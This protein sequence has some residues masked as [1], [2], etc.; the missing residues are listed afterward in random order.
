MT[1]LKIIR[2]TVSEKEVSVLLVTA[3]IAASGVLVV[4]A[5]TWFCN[6]LS[7][8]KVYD[9]LCAA[10]P[11]METVEIIGLYYLVIYIRRGVQKIRGGK[12]K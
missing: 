2:K 3:G 9:Y 1:V 8:R 5:V 10:I 7:D 4:F 6:F 11:L 12:E